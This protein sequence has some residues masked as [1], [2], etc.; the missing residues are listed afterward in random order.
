MKKTTKR[1]AKSPKKR[2]KN[3]P[4]LTSYP[5]GIAWETDFKPESLG[6]M[7]DRSVAAYGART[8]TNF[9]GKTSTYSEIGA[10]SDRVA[11]GLQ[12]LGVG[13]GTKVGLLLPN[14][15]AF[16]IFYFGILK[17]KAQVSSLFC[18]S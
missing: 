11:K 8:C 15:P 13:K 9:L 1:P 10:A 3:I 18:A 12:E 2:Q 14:C 7:L 6:A 17:N 5:A 4:W 16:V